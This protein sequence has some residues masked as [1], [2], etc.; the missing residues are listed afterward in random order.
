[1]CGKPEQQKYQEASLK[2]FSSPPIQII[3][4]LA[5]INFIKPAGVQDH[6]HSVDTDLLTFAMEE[7]TYNNNIFVNSDFQRYAY[8]VCNEFN[9]PYPPTTSEEALELFF[10]LLQEFDDYY[11]HITIRTHVK[12]I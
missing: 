9:R 8:T 2:C 4:I 1:M 7:Y 10:F 6:K 11:I 12:N 5:N 3:V